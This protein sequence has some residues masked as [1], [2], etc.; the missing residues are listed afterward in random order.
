MA[1]KPT[2]LRTVYW[3]NGEVIMID[4]R[5]L[6]H[7]LKLL[8]CRNYRQVATAIKNMAIRG[9]PA[10]G[11]AA[12]YGLALA[13]H[14]S[15]RLDAKKKLEKLQI[16]ADEL[17]ATR[18]TA[19]NLF[20]AIE[21]VM[22]R[23]EAAASSN[24]DIAS[25][26]LEEAERMAEE[27]VET[28][29]RIGRNG[30]ELLPDKATVMTY[31]NAGALATVA[32]G[33][34]LGVVR[35]A[36]EQGKAIRVIVPETRPKLQGARLTAYELRHEGIEYRVI[37][38]SMAPFLISRGMVDCVIVGADR[39]IARTGHVVNKIGTLGLALAAK[40]FGVPFY[41]AAPL[42]SFDFARTIDEVKIEERSEDEVLLVEG[43]RIAPRGSR[44][45]N[46]AFDITPPELV[47]L[48]ITEHGVYKP[49]ELQQ[50]GR[51]YKL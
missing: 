39:V 11:V 2:E 38:D 50:L 27:D 19:I 33:T 28:N 41:V 8:R 7:R 51:Y 40:H 12:A 14:A 46:Y 26:V 34:A 42:S 31:C 35:A 15:R 29:R 36:V 48:V 13:A 5:L 37:S 17:R 16:A 49:T 43:V 22:S 47:S 23:A 6:P 30:A 4:Q 1:R 3:K 9:A 21:R 44:A 45:L 10:I 20:W 32:Y 18:P 24:I 25:A